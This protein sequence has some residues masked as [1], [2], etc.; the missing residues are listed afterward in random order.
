MTVK[1]DFNDKSR[2]TENLKEAVAES[3]LNGLYQ[4][5]AGI[6]EFGLHVV[7][8]KPSQRFVSGFIESFG[9]ASR[10]SNDVDASVNPIHIISHG[11]DVEMHK[12]KG[13][14]TVTPS[15]SIYLR[16]LPREEDLIS[17][18]TQI[19]LTNDAQDLL[20]DKINVHVEN[21]KR[22]NPLP[23]KKDESATDAW[24]KG[25]ADVRAKAMH[26]SLIEV[27]G[28]QISQTKTTDVE[29][30]E[31]QKLE[32]LTAKEGEDKSLTDTVDAEDQEVQEQ[33][34]RDLFAFEVRPGDSFSLKDQLFKHV[35]PLQ[36]WQRLDLHDL[37]GLKFYADDDD[38]V[39]QKNLI[40]YNTQ[41]NSTISEKIRVWL[42]DDSENGGR[43]WA[44]PSKLRVTP[45]DI[46]NWPEKLDEIRKT[47]G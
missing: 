24:Y 13:Q 10:L 39:I 19:S 1:V 15:F 26:E 34:S 20:Y 46:I 22:D 29:V 47:I 28:E 31:N 45:S 42:Y 23:D 11:F 40:T 9:L 6:G 37:P 18:P 38:S 8:K 5:A 32:N 35:P 17:H 2:I 3:I 33:A 4:R 36:R 16:V 25:M 30:E 7:D 43:N 12:K 14:V 21:Y 44:F 27:L 41:I